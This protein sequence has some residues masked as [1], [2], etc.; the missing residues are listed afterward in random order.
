VISTGKGPEVGDWN[1][2][3]VR[4][5]GAIAPANFGQKPVYWKAITP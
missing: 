5:N 1:G 3:S 4:F 2:A